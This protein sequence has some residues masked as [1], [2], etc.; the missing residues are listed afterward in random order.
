MLVREEEVELVLDDRT[1]DGKAG[2][3]ILVREHGQRHRI[4]R[5][6]LIAAEESVS[7]SGDV[8]GAGLGGRLH[9]HTG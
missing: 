7:D 9:L 1:A 2:L 3:L 8:V 5:V 4:R 6:E